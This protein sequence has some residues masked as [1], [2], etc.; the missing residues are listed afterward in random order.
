[1]KTEPLSTDGAGT[2]SLAVS[3]GRMDVSGWRLAASKQLG[4]YGISGGL[5]RENYHATVDFAA[6]SSSDPVAGGSANLMF[7]AKLQRRIHRR[8]FWEWVRRPWARSL[9]AC[10]VGRHPRCSFLGAL[11]PGNA[12]PTRSGDG[13]GVACAW[14]QVVHHALFEEVR[15]ARSRM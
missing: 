2:V 13:R 3:N 1:M 6:Y 15:C 9:E 8:F 11:S 5:G 12:S 7:D 14:F 4:R 10:S